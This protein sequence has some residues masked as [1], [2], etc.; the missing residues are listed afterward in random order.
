M[1]PVF[2]TIKILDHDVF[3]LEQHVTRM[4]KTSKDLFRKEIY[5]PLLTSDIEKQCRHGLQKCKVFYN[6]DK[7]RIECEPY[8]KRDIK[9]LIVV[10]DNE[11]EY[12]YKY[13]DRAC[14]LKHTNRLS[15]K[16]DIL[17]VK[18]N[19]L[20]DTSYSNV[21]LWNGKE[22][23]TPLHPLFHGIKRTILLQ[24]GNIKEQDILLDD[25]NKYKKISL[26]NAMLDL[27]DMELNIENVL[28]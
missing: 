28:Y 22:W 10:M 6:K 7:Y 9:K 25:L 23:H 27:G 12:R 14:F 15:F 11:I 16:D 20:R 24:K 8:M 26:I 2:E 13:T 19:R 3:H 17:L 1:Y 4:K 21:A 5:F 18:S